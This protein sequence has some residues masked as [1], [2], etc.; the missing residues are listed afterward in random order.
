MRI[1]TRINAYVN[2]LS[3]ADTRP[4]YSGQASTYSESAPKNLQGSQIP[5]DLF[6]FLKEMDSKLNTILS[7]LSR[8]YLQDQFEHTCIVT[9]ISGAGLQFTSKEEFKEGQAVEMAV[10]VSQMPFRIVGLVGAIQRIEQEKE[11]KIYVVEYTSIREEDREAI[12][13][14]VFQEQRELIRRQHND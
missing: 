14:F 5:A 3:S 4:M 10:I 12:V 7:L 13:Q 2:R 6:K 11:E 9:E 8:D 1:S